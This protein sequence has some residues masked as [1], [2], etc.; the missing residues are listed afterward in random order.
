MSTQRLCPFCCRDFDLTDSPIVATVLDTALGTRAAASSVASL[1]TGPEDPGFALDEGEDDDPGDDPWAPA[2]GPG[3]HQVPS[4]P[5]VG[6]SAPVEDDPEHPLRQ[7]RKVR[8]LWEPDPDAVP[9]AEEGLLSSF[10][11]GLSGGARRSGRDLKPLGDFEVSDMPR[12][13]C[14][15]CQTPLPL[16]ADRAEMQ[17]LAIAGLNSVGKSHFL[18][19]AFDDAIENGLDDIGCTRFSPDGP[20]DQFLRGRVEKFLHRGRPLDSTQEHTDLRYRALTFR[21]LVRQHASV[22]L[23]HDINGESIADDGARQTHA[24]FLRRAAGLIF[25]VDPLEFRSLRAKRPDYEPEVSRVATQANILD[26]CLQEMHRVPGG[27]EVPIA[28]TI[29]KSDLLSE[30]LGRSHGFDK[31]SIR[32]PG[33]LEEIKTT[34]AEIREL[35]LEIGERRLV[36]VAD[37]HG[38]VSYH[39]VSPMGS[40]PHLPSFRPEPRRCVEPLATVLVRMAAA[41]ANGA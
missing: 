6:P 14:P 26:L 37:R 10:R 4:P 24:S 32:G 13:A 35:L 25:L 22:L 8:T 2:G 36:E 3:V 33:W 17:I 30:M 29:S 9:P 15:H 18:V 31:E 27:K 20:T 41:A 5:V 38:V 1:P 39:A 7:V 34:S 21:S 23:T 40:S 28:L 12:R 16:D 19:A 11:R